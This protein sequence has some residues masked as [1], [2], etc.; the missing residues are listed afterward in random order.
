MSHDAEKPTGHNTP[1]RFAEIV[2]YCCRVEKN[3]SGA[4]EAHCSP[5]PRIFKLCH[6]LAAVEITKLVG[7]DLTTG[8]VVIPSD[9]SS[10]KLV[11]KATWKDVS[12]YKRDDST[13]N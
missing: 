7:T 8:E 11:V 10:E 13:E 6:G 9:A 4:P 1:C 12:R 5:I 3:S 2:Q